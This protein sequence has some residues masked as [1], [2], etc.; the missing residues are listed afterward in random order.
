MRWYPCNIQIH[1]I[2]IALPRN[3]CYMA[4]HSLHAFI[5]SS[6]TFVGSVCIKKYRKLLFQSS[7]NVFFFNQ[8]DW[9]LDIP[10]FTDEIQVI[11]IKVFFRLTYTVGP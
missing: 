8:Y 2:L 4:L 11:L 9:F 10:V 3:D 6:V 5:L 1:Q 7:L